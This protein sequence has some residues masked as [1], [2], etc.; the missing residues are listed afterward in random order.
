MVRKGDGRSARLC[1]Y[2]FESPAPG[3]KTN[4]YTGRYLTLDANR[5]VKQSF[6]AGEPAPATPN[7]HSNDFIEIRLTEVD[8]SRTELTFTNV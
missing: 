6:L 4:F 1:T 3:G 2:H 5:C 8:D 7:P